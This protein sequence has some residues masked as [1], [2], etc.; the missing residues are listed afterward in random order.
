MYSV[1]DPLILILFSSSPPLFQLLTGTF[2]QDDDI[3]EQRAPGCLVLHISLQYIHQVKPLWTK[4]P[5]LVQSH[6]GG[7]PFSTAYPAPNHRFSSVMHCFYQP[8]ALLRC[9]LLSYTTIT[10]HRLP[11]WW[12]SRENPEWRGLGVFNRAFVHPKFYFLPF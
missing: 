9:T 7:E 2:T 1:F 11:C 5:S 12:N 3:C 4:C 10:N 8:H 6:P